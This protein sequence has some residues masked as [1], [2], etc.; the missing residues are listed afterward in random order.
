MHRHYCPHA[1]AEDTKVWE[2][3]E[4]FPKSE[5]GILLEEVTN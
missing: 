5:N 2:G 1:A 4:T 3:E